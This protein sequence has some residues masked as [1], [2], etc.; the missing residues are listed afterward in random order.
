M[1]GT[2]LLKDNKP[3]RTILAYMSY[4]TFQSPRMHQVYNTHINIDTLTMVTSQLFLVTKWFVKWPLVPVWFWFF[5]VCFL[6]IAPE[7]YKAT[8]PNHVNTLLVL[9][10]S[11]FLLGFFFPFL[12]LSPPF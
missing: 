5:F 10:I 2:H 1:K 12:S 6:F 11:V 4:L 9:P 7:G 3:L 8:Q